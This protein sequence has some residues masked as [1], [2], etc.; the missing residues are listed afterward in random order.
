MVRLC[1]RID[2]AKL[3]S[4]LS[5]RDGVEYRPADVA[6]WLGWEGFFPLGDRWQC[7]GDL[8]VLED[9]EILEVVRQFNYDG[10]TYTVH[11]AA[12]GPLPI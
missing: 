6:N 3:T 5:K 12:V 8:S 11:E 10:I 9:D 2:L 1:V 7:Q 4:R